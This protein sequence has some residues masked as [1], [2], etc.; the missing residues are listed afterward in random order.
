MTTLIE[1][2]AMTAIRRESARIFSPAIGRELTVIAYG[3]AGVPVL[4]FP[5]SEGSASD[6]EGFG[7]VDALSPLLRAGKL[8]LYCVDSYDSESWWA[9]HRPAHERA[10]RHTL[11]EDWIINNV[12]PA[13]RC[14]LRDD[15]AR[16]IATGCSFGA[17]HAANFTLKHPRHFRTALCMSG[18]YNLN[19]LLDGHHDEFVYFNNPVEYVANLHGELLDELRRSVF[20]ALIS[21]QG[22][23]EERSLQSTREFWG[24]LSR[25]Q[26][27]NYMDLWGADAGHDWPWWRRQIVY[28]LSHFVE[29]RT[30]WPNIS[31]A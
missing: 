11:Y 9:K 28:Y 23:W 8:R 10:W 26:L 27:P 13:I 6:Y 12:L 3:D 15:E 21:G 5:T 4:V 20:I 24:V 22:Q 14:D 1:T 2:P 19:W 18:A 25:K 31:L 29:G 7:M 17:Y 30:P 16:L